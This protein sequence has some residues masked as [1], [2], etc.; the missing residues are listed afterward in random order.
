VLARIEP[1]DGPLPAIDN[2]MADGLVLLV[3]ITGSRHAASWRASRAI[4]DPTITRV[5]VATDDITDGAVLSVAARSD[6]EFVAAWQTMVGR[7]AASAQ[8][9]SEGS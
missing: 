7:P 4:S 3:V 2:D 1:S 6:D 8:A 5:L 9:P